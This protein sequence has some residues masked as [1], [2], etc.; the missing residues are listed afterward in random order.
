M[1]RCKGKKQQVNVRWL[2]SGADTCEIRT[3]V[4]TILCRRFSGI[5]VNAY[6]KALLVY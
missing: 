1:Y 5:Y 3:F 2:A 4:E 6:G